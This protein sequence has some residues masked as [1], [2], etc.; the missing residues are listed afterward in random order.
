[1]RPKPDSTPVENQPNLTIKKRANRAAQWTMSTWQVS[2]SNLSYNTPHQ[3]FA[4]MRILG[5]VGRAARLDSDRKV[6]C[7]SKPLLSSD[8]SIALFT[9][10]I[11]GRIVHSN[12]CISC[13]N[14]RSEAESESGTRGASTYYT[15]HAN[16][17]RVSAIVSWRAWQT[18]QSN[19]LPSSRQP[20]GL[21]EINRRD[22]EKSGGTT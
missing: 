21:Q 12:V 22:P 4:V 2:E 6:K 5:L 8:G 16:R 17:A 18:C 19:E 11:T 20:L 10:F 15:N 1:M 14:H 9:A 13:L 3:V 7:S